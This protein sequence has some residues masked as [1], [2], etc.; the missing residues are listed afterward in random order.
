[1]LR[2]HGGPHASS[3]D[4][5]SVDVALLLSLGIAVVLPQFRGTLGYGRAFGDSLLGRAGIDDV[6]DCAA[7]ARAA[8][9]R[10]PDE[11]DAARGA[12]FGGS[13]GGFLGAWLVGSPRHRDLFRAA[14]L[15]NPVV[16]L[17]AMVGTTDIPEWCAAEGFGKAELRWPLSAD[18][19]L[20]LRERSPL[21]AVADVRASVLVLLG[22]GDERVPP[23]QGRQYV[24]ALQA[25]PSPP[26]VEVNEYPGEGHSLAG[27][28]AN[29]HA[30]QSAVA[31][32][33]EHLTN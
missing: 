26:R 24:S 11:I 23:S 32:L 5:F 3:L 13:H 4:A 31:F 30:V 6:E 27:A 20:T 33:R 25:Q 17:P 2:P 10:F 12:V 22:S 1:M 15:W 14:V 7:L 28:E 9:A 19:L 29:A 8:L 16:D 21:S 18:E